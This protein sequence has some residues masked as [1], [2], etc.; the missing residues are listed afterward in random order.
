MHSNLFDQSPIIEYLGGLQFFP[1]INSTVVNILLHTSLHI[2]Q[3]NFL[4]KI[5]GSK[6]M[7]TS[8]FSTCWQIDL[9]ED[10]QFYAFTKSIWECLYFKIP[11]HCILLILCFTLPVWQM[12]YEMLL[13]IRLNFFPYLY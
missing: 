6:S 8:D 4:A 2:V 5:V 3:L 7:H 11:P 9:K 12:T 13:F 1:I 10:C